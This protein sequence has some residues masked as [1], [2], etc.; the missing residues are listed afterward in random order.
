[1]TPHRARVLL[2]YQHGSLEEINT[3]FFWINETVGL[4]FSCCFFPKKKAHVLNKFFYPTLLAQ[5]RSEGGYLLILRRI[6]SQNLVVSLNSGD[7]AELWLSRNCN[8]QYKM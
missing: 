2:Q 5:L 8:L 3:R 7:F 4:L 1:M 6:T